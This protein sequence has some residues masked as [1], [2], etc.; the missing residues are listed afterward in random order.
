MRVLLGLLAAILLA[1]CGMTDDKTV[2]EDI[3]P[4]S[5]ATAKIDAEFKA[6]RI[7]ASFT[8][9]K[10]IRG[11]TTWG[12]TFLSYSAGYSAA[13]RDVETFLQ[14]THAR[15]DSVMYRT[16]E[17]CPPFP[18]GEPYPADPTALMKL[19]ID[20][21]VLDRCA[22]IESWYLPSSE[23]KHD[24]AS[25]GIYRAYPPP[26]ADGGHQ[27]NVVISVSLPESQS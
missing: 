10:A 11:H 15:K 21:G 24:K 9:I 19:W 23:L 25:S 13:Q 4:A 18:P 14:D 6:A 20:Y 5:E 16:K 7:P 2:N 27:T 8:P 22:T 12:S 26:N 3:T 17:G 1:A